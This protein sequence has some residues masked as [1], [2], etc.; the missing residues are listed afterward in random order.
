MERIANNINEF[1]KLLDQWEDRLIAEDKDLYRCPVCRDTG[2]VSDGVNAYPCGCNREQAVGARKAAAGLSPKL[3]RSTFATFSLDY[4]SKAR[5]EDLPL[6]YRQ[7]AEKA[8]SSCRDFVESYAAGRR[9]RGLMLIGETGCGKTHLAAAVAN[10]LVARGVD[11]L[12]LVVPEFL[13]QLRG[14]YRRE[15]EGLDETELVRRAYAAPVL[16]LDDLGAHNFSEWVQ[17]KLF[18]IV[19]YRLNNEL[20]CVITTNLPPEELNDCI[21]IRTTS[22]LLEGCVLRLLAAERDIRKELYKR[23]FA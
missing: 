22:R 8:L 3:A 2:W 4:Y 7:L 5:R 19:N 13:D 21:G 15:N 1:N 11:P 14:S 18:T 6:S 10:E 17:N 16:V 20:P 9:R 12:F 23:G